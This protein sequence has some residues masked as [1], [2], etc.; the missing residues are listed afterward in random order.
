[1]KNHIDLYHNN[2]INLKALLSVFWRQKIW[3]LFFSC[4]S[5]LYGSYYLQ[6]AERK[7]TIEYKLKPVSEENQNR[8][9]PRLGG[10]ASLAG[11]QLPSNSNAD[12]KIFIELIS[13]Y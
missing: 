5:V 7:Y 1:M 11:I 4:L 10:I 9:I 3:I 12:F 13:S 2:E 8:T 6:S